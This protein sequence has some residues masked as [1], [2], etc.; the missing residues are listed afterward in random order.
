MNSLFFQFTSIL[1]RILCIHGKVQFVTDRN[2]NSTEESR[3]LLI[4]SDNVG[5]GHLSGSTF[6]SNPQSGSGFNTS[7][8]PPD[9]PVWNK[10]VGNEY[11]IF[12]ASRTPNVTQTKPSRASEIQM[13]MQ[14]M[15]GSVQSMMSVIASNIIREQKLKAIKREWASVA[16]VLDRLFFILYIIAITVSLVLTFPKPPSDYATKPLN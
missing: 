10:D 14:E 6:C 13:E 9:P 3:G 7:P 15:K 8:Y 11:G 12:S 1:S 16:M 5:N 4:G 2:S